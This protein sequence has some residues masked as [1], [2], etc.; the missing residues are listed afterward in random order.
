MLKRDEKSKDSA[1]MREGGGF[2]VGVNLTETAHKIH[3]LRAL[4][5]SCLWQTLVEL[6]FCHTLESAPGQTHYPAIKLQL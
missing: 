3:K 4:R 6:R 1:H 2:I 5:A